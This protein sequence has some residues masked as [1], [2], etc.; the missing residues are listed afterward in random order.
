MRL[1]G[2]ATPPTVPLSATGPYASG[3]SC[4]AHL[5]FVHLHHDVEG[6]LNDAPYLAAKLTSQLLL[7]QPV[8]GG[9]LLSNAFTL[10][11][12]LAHLHSSESQCRHVCVSTYT[13]H[14]M[15]H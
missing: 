10:H 13:E 3:N 11:D 6:L 2:I 7:Q 1:Q 4:S 9:G 12:P 5:V 14:F 8:S 15:H